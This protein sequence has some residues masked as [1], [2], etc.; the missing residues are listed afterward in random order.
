M[1]RGYTVLEYKSIVR[2]LRAAR[3]GICVS[4]DFIVGFPGETERDFEATL[5]LVDEIGFDDSYSFV[6]SR[7]PGTPAADLADPTPQHVKAERLSQLKEKIDAQAKG[8]A[9]RMVGTRQRVL[10]EGASHRNPG[11]LA[12]RTGNNRMVNFPGDTE[13]VGQFRRGD[14]HRR[15]RALAARRAAARGPGMQPPPWRSHGLPSPL[16]PRPL[17]L[18]LS[19][20]DN[21]RLANL[22]GALDENLRQ[23][24]TA[25][26]VTIARRGERFTLR[27]VRSAQRAPRCCRN[28]TRA[29]A[30]GLT[31]DDVQLGLIELR[32]R[33]GGS[34]REEAPLLTRRADLHGRTPRQRRYLQ[35]ILEHD[36]TFAIGPA[37]TG[38]TYLAVAC[39]VDALEREAVKRIVLVRPAVEAGE[40][41]GFLPGDL[42]QKVDP[43][44]RPLYDALYDLLGFD[45]VRQAVRARRDRARAAR[46]HARPHAQPLLRHP[47]RSAEHHAGADEDVPHPHRLRLQGRDHRRRHADRP[48]ARAEE[49]PG[50]GAEDPRRRCAASPSASSRAKTSCATRWCSASSTPTSATRRSSRRARP[51]LAL[52]RDA[53]PRSASTCS[54]RSRRAASRSRRRRASGGWARVALTAARRD[55][56]ARRRRCRSAAPEPLLPRARLCHQRARVCVSRAARRDPRATSCCARR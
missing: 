50:R 8:I 19:P 43:Y 52:A 54:C 49:R 36:I 34:A 13:H 33:G 32:A 21:Q 22:C 9:E 15:P 25:L 14:R 2:R 29:P 47:R 40:R 16:K 20:V 51:G 12:G 30:Q 31:I 27:G 18:V 38:K 28:S 24:E 55:H 7:R 17:E 35:N 46:L 41:L 6:Y 44:L 39:A 45:R 3:P 1:K 53:T 56:R 4:S 11:E 37:G 42:A 48:R 26:D 5:R 23:I 10:V